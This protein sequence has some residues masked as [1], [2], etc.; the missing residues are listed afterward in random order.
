[1]LICD[2]VLKCSWDLEQVTFGRH[3]QELLT[4][5]NQGLKFLMG[6]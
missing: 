6:V 3:V 1:M 4:A 2:V 5:R